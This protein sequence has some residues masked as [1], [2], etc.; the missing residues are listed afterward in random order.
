MDSG[1]LERRARNLYVISG[2]II[3]Y[4]LAGA[5]LGQLSALGFRAPAVYPQ[6]YSYAVVLAFIWF[7][8]RYDVVWRRSQPR[9]TFQQDYLTELSNHP[10]YLRH[11]EKEIGELILWTITANKNVITND[12]TQLRLLSIRANWDTK[13]MLAITHFRVNIGSNTLDCALSDFGQGD[14]IRASVSRWVHLRSGTVVYW[15]RAYNYE[16]FATVV[17]PNWVAFFALCLMILKAFFID[18]GGL[19]G[20]LKKPASL[21]LPF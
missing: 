14:P 7:W 1:K 19:F 12:H 20:I 15:R 3:V 5:D 10:L 8:W 9:E 16:H 13:R 2:A 11:L 17:A 4:L 6:V 18:P 21:S